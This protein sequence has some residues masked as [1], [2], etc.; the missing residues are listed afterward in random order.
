MGS[1]SSYFG[2]KFWA[3]YDGYEFDADAAMADLMH[4]TEINNQYAVETL[5]KEVADLAG[6]KAIGK[7][8]DAVGT[9]VSHI[10]KRLAANPNMSTETF[11]KYLDLLNSTSDQGKRVEL[12]EK[13]FTGTKDFDKMLRRAQ[14]LEQLAIDCPE[15]AQQIEEL[16]KNADNEFNHRNTN[17]KK[18]ES[19]T[20]YDPNAIWG[21]SGYNTFKY[22]NNTDLQHFIIGFENV[23]TARADAQVV[24]IRDTLDKNVFD[25]GSFELGDITIGDT[26]I[27]MP[28]GR[29]QVMMQRQLSPTMDVRINARLDTAT[30]EALWVFT[31]IDR[32]TEDVPELAGFLPPNIT[33]PAGEG[34]VMYKLK[35]KPNLPHLTPMRS[36]ASIYFDQNEPIVTNTWQNIIDLAPPTTSLTA[37]RI[38]DTTIR[39]HISGADAHAGL[40]SFNVYVRQNG[41]DWMRLSQQAGDTLLF[42]GRPDSTYSFYA[43]GIDSLRNAEAK[44]ASAEA[45]ITLDSS[46]LPVR[47]TAF[48]GRALQTTNQL[49]WS[50]ATETNNHGFYVERS[51]DGQKFTDAG[52]VASQAM[53]GNSHTRLTYHFADTNPATVTYYRLRQV[54]KDGTPT[55]SKTIWINR[56]AAGSNLVVAPNPAS[57]YFTLQSPQPISQLRLLDMQGRLIQAFVP[58]AES[59]YTLPPL[60]AGLYLLV[61]THAQ[62]THTQRLHI[63]Q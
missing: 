36:K 39:I 49:Y 9:R 3:W 25:L 53:G 2:K 54:D 33:K 4:E 24:V 1:A 44:T 46:M 14:S 19:N 7:V 52:F 63:M 30:G 12:L 41:K 48:S 18:T 23:D 29:Q 28:A 42:E 56:N 40:G 8:K 38:G 37:T 61:I 55:Q 15:L 47:F 22:V 26:L 27:R 35:P 17:D 62:G 21:P 57:R 43:E 51:T 32:A 31:A 34:Y 50:T 60:P 58:N 5:V 20:S 13:M 11:D 45:T 16:K 59:R 10:N 6:S